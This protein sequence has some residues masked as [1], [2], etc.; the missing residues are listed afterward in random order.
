MP[1]GDEEDGVVCWVTPD[2]NVI[3][4]K[5]LMSEE[6][7]PLAMFVAASDSDSRR[8]KSKPGKK[9]APTEPSLFPDDWGPN[10]KELACRILDALNT[11]QLPDELVPRRSGE[12]VDT[13][14]RLMAPK[15][16]SIM[17]YNYSTQ[18]A[19]VLGAYYLNK[20]DLVRMQQIFKIFEH[21]KTP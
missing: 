14:I 7:P 11:A 18:P 6:C 13:V 20:G 17:L 8:A 1:V 4:E 10:K 21:P 3:C 19:D 5:V 16:P 12:I 9:A 15:P 2:G